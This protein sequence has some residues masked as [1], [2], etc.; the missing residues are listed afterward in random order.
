MRARAHCLAVM[1]VSLLT[2]AACAG[3]PSRDGTGMA[4]NDDAGK[5]SPCSRAGD[6][7]VQGL[8]RTSSGATFTVQLL[9]VDPAPP[10][11]GENT[12]TFEVSDAK[13][14]ATGLEIIMTSYM[15]DHGHAGPSIDVRERSFSEYQAS[16]NIVLMSGLYRFAI[17]RSD[18][19]DD[20]AAFE[21]CVR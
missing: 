20:V 10:A 8:A 17:A 2:L 12:W 4:A 11:M 3:T 19:R 9:D 13:G 7:Y 14:P 6:A 1:L 5:Q 21:F 15:P 16:M 18:R